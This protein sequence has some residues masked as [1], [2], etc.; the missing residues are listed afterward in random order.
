MDEVIRKERLCYQQFKNKNEGLKSQ[1]SKEKNKISG[2]VKKP[3]YCIMIKFGRDHQHKM[4]SRNNQCQ[5]TVSRWI[6]TN[7]DEQ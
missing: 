6:K 4:F 1:L 3:K 7:G 5:N 2:G